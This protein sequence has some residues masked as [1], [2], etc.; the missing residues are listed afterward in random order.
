MELR[1]P[2]DIREAVKSLKRAWT[3]YND[4]HQCYIQRNDN[5]GK[6]YEDYSRRVKAV[7]DQ[8]PLLMRHSPNSS[9]KSREKSPN[10]RR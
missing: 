2:D 3:R 1:E 8:L 10:Y 4:M 6:I 5:Y 7:D 9:L